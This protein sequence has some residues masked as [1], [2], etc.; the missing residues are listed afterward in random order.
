MATT[1]NVAY[2]TAVDL[3]VT[4]LQSLGSSLTSGWQ[5]ARISNM[6]TKALDYEIGIKLA[7]ANTLPASDKVAYVYISEAHLLQD[8]STWLHDD[9]GVTT[10]P[11]GSEGAITVLS[12]ATGPMS[13][14]LLGTIPYY[15]Q[16][17]PMQR[18]FKLSTVAGMF[19]SGGFSIIIVN[20]TGAAL[21]SSGNIVS[22]TA[23]TE[24][25]T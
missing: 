25:T 16:N 1:N 5:S 17:A 15:T 24:T 7:P 23:I 10:L 2:G 9:V 12:N 3:T 8:G 20:F 11:S 6:S 13:A 4:A 18:T 21:L 19:I 22:V 14:K